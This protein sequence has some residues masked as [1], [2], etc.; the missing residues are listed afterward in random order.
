M[1]MKNRNPR[2]RARASAAA[3]DFR[4]RRDLAA[5]SAQDRLALPPEVV[6]SFFR[7][8]DLNEI[9]VV[10]KED[11]LG[12]RPNLPFDFVDAAPPT[13]DYL[14]LRK[15]TDDRAREIWCVR[16]RPERGPKGE[17]W[18]TQFDRADVARAVDAYIR[19]FAVVRDE[20]LNGIAP[21][22]RLVAD[23]LHDYAVLIAARHAAREL[24][25]KGFENYCDEIK[26][27]V[28]VIDGQRVGDLTHAHG[29]ALAATL[30]ASYGPGVVARTMHALRRAVEEVL[31]TPR[32]PYVAAFQPPR[33]PKTPRRSFTTEEML[34][35]PLAA[36]NNWIWDAEANDW[37]TAVDPETGL[38]VRVGRPA[39]VADMAWG[40]ARFFV[41]GHVFGSRRAINWAFKWVDDGGPF[42]D[43]VEGI[44]HRLGKAEQ[45]NDVKPRGS[46]PIPQA[47][48]PMFKAWREA[49]RAAGIDYVVHNWAGEPMRYLYRPAWEGL[50]EAAGAQK[51]TPHALK[52]TCVDVLRRS[53]CSAESAAAYLYTDPETLRAYY[54]TWGFDTM[55]M[56][57]DT[58][59]TFGVEYRMAPSLAPLDVPFDPRKPANDNRRRAA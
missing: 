28:P 32:R 49:D 44:C 24:S 11:D 39:H 45:G 43:V 33:V 5:M 59:S 38:T 9:A 16:M 22:S 6:E 47:Y 7:L 10:W 1:A 31:S 37:K 8:P 30:A 18:S 50:L 56:A 41:V 14:F 25:Q 40:F 19:Y 2:N 54:G 52:H 4:L 57:A 35:V 46:C 34:R 36:E 53:G 55:R 26:R 15:P 42:I 12:P 13:G 58:L 29:K 20:V 48:L 23:V 51:L 27:L 3:A 21:E 17:R